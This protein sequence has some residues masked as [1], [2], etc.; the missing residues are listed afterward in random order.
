M[1]C[2][3]IFFT[4]ARFGGRGD[5]VVSASALGTGGPHFESRTGNSFSA[6]RKKGF[7]LCFHHGGC[8]HLYQKKNSNCILIMMGA[9]SF[10]KK[11]I[12]IVFWS[13][14]VHPPILKKDTSNS[15]PPISK[16][17]SNCI[18][19]IVVAST[20]ILQPRWLWKFF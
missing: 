11:R 13:W 6:S 2:L 12:Q 18:M 9:S 1:L 16:K 3:M 5:W 15:N 10:I 7:K 4:H 8:I 14:W 20:L 19:I 17:Y